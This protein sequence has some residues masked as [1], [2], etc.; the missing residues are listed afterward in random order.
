MS[1]YALQDIEK[2]EE[3]CISYTG[4][5]VKPEFIKEYFFFT[6]SCGCKEGWKCESTPGCFGWP[7]PGVLKG[8]DKEWVCAACGAE[9]KC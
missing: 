3:C 6:C 5:Q 4:H 7:V 8:S 9:L 2:G 1:F